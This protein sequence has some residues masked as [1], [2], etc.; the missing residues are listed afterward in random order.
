MTNHNMMNYKSIKHKNLVTLNIDNLTLKEVHL[1]AEI[2]D[3]RLNVEENE[4]VLDEATIIY[5]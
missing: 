1:R 2:Y 3:A 4:L 5:K